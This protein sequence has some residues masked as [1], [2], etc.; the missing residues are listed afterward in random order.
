M[1]NQNYEVPH[2]V[3]SP[4]W[5]NQQSLRQC[6]LQCIKAYWPQK[7]PDDF[8]VFVHTI[9]LKLHSGIMFSHHQIPSDMQSCTWAFLY[10]LALLAQSGPNV[11]MSITWLFKLFNCLCN[12]SL[13]HSQFHETC[14]FN[15]THKSFCSIIFIIT[16]GPHCWI[17]CLRLGPNCSSWIGWTKG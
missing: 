13:K 17:P 6:R 9:V 3:V 4:Y 7:N 8:S 16:I 14:I 11:P 2:V 15:D 1:S 12:Q 10:C 5:L